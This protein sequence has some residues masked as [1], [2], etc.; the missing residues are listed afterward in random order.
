MEQEPTQQLKPRSEGQMNWS[1]R[2]GRQTQGT[3]AEARKEM[4]R[5]FKA[6]IARMVSC[7]PRV[8]LKGF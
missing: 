4:G 1:L 3:K 2:K 7:P 8:S 6:T 5:I